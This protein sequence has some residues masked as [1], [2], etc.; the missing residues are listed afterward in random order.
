ME[1]GWIKLQYSPVGRKW[2]AQLS[3]SLPVSIIKEVEVWVQEGTD[4]PRDAEV[5][6]LYRRRE[7][8]LN[9]IVG[10]LEGQHGRKVNGRD[11][12]RILDDQAGWLYT[13]TL[14]G[15]MREI[16]ESSGRMTETFG[17]EINL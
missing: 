5:Y 2:T 7:N 14:E 13:G 8:L 6:A 15:I 17:W 16:M 1:K 11:A 12:L 10:M 4:Y 3:W 9:W